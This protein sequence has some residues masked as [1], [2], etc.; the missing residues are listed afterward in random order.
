M[1]IKREATPGLPE[2]FT[3]RFDANEFVTASGKRIPYAFTAGTIARAAGGKIKLNV[4][5]PAAS[6]PRDY[7][8]AAKLWLEFAANQQFGSK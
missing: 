4:W 6:V 2:Y 7:R 1:Q 8:K 3:V 5:T